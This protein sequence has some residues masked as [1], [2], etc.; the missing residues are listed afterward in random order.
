MYT[1]LCQYH[2]KETTE[3]R[4]NWPELNLTP[5]SKLAFREPAQKLK[6]ICKILCNVKFRIPVTNTHI[7]VYAYLRP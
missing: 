1:H 5:C 4:L 3:E 6:L 2:S 7:L